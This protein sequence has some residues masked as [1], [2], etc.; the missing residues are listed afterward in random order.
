V[1]DSKT[2]SNPVR[3][4]K[5]SRGKS[6]YGLPETTPHSVLSFDLNDTFPDFSA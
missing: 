1:L 5:L 4:A 6:V 3:V 2:G